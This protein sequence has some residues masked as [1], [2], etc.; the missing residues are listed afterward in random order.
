MLTL[1]QSEMIFEKFGRGVTFYYPHPVSGE[2]EPALV[3][4][5][6]LDPQRNHLSGVTVKFSDGERMVIEA[7]KF[8]EIKLPGE[9]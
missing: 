9:K 8:L 4:G 5:Y 6:A 3:T 2:W 1:Q 7:E